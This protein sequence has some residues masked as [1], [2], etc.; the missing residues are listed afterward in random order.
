MQLP[1][2]VH[3][4]KE[5]E[6]LRRARLQTET[7][8]LTTASPENTVI[9]GTPVPGSPWPWFIGWL[10]AS[11]LLWWLERSRLGKDSR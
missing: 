7:L 11:S 2:Y 8:K 1:F 6:A 5:G 3:A 10:L 4:P 9:S